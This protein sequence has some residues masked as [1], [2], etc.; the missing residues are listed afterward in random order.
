MAATLTTTRTLPPPQP[1]YIGSPGRTIAVYTLAWVSHTDG[2]VA[3]A[4]S[5][6]VVGEILRV[7]P[8]TPTT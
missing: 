6:P 4:T 7:S 2:S 5:V 3:L 8:R 1:D